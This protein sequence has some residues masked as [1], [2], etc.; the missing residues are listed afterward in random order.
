MLL[1]PEHSCNGSRA[2]ADQEKQSGAGGCIG[3][4]CGSEY[5]GDDECGTD[6]HSGADQRRFF[7]VVF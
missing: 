1:L 5:A 6:A 2:G 4:I 3:F 7:D